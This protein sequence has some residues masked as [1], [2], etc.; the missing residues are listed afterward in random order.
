MPVTMVKVRIVRMAVGERSVAMPV[1]MGFARRV[2]GPVV[3]LVV[4]VVLMGVIVLEPFVS[5]LVAVV[6]GDV[7]PHAH[8]H[9]GC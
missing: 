8:G 2:F 5:V 7:Q 9:E 3:V 6:F 1:G 4:F